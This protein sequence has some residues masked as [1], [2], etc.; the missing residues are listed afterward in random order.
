MSKFNITVEYDFFDE[1]PE[2]S[3]QELIAREIASQIRRDIISDTTGYWSNE[4]QKIS[5]TAKNEIVKS[6]VNMVSDDVLKALE[7]KMEAKLNTDFNKLLVDKIQERIKKGIQKEI[8]ES[9]QS[10]IK[11]EVKNMFSKLG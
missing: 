6:V 5:I 9:I 2:E 3:L 8:Q 4:V 11:S 1:Y 7:S 10:M